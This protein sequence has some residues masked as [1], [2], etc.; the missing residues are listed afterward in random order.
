M[1]TQTAPK[2]A[3]GECEPADSQDFAHRDF[4]SILREHQAMVFSIAFNFLRNRAIAE[5]LAQDVFLSLYQNLAA[6]KSREH[7]VLW[8]RKVTINRC[9]D[10][11][12]RMKF[13]SHANIADIAEPVQ[14]PSQVDVLFS[15]QLE[16][17]MAKLPS[18][19]RSILVLRYQ[20]DLEPADI[21]ELLEMPVNTVKSHL[22]RA[23]ARLREELKG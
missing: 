20:E 3:A 18:K 7:L 8:L 13:R 22:R 5:E 23:L 4:E 17:C 6:I 12:R 19:A 9:M 21:A 10:H 11:G 16:R 14:A 1:T 15:K 2:L